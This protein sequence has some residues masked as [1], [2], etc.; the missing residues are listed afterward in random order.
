M[1]D[2]NVARYDKLLHYLS[3]TTAL[4]VLVYIY[5]M[6]SWCRLKGPTTAK[7]GLMCA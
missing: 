5:V 7:S 3:V 1:F 4:D 6:F 2:V